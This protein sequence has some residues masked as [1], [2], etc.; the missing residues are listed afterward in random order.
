MTASN[1][2]TAISEGNQYSLLKILGLWTVT[3]LPLA[4]MG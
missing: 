1:S 4:F 2:D 3:A